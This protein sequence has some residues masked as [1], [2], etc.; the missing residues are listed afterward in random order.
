MNV[1]ALRYDWP[2]VN[3]M[4]VMFL[5]REQTSD[6]EAIDT[7]VRL[8]V[9]YVTTEICETYDETASVYTSQ[10]ELYIY[11]EQSE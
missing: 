2:E 7:T 4:A 11:G 10:V 8:A 3:V 5:L 9:P 6:C 1:P